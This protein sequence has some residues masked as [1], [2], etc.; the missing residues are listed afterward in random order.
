MNFFWIPRLCILTLLVLPS[1]AAQQVAET[2]PQTAGTLRSG[3]VISRNYSTEPYVIEKY[4]TAWRFENDGTAD[5]TITARIRIQNDVAARQF[6]ELSFAFDANAEELRVAFLRVRKSDG[7]VVD[8]DPH[9]ITE[10][11]S[12][13]VRDAPAFTNAKEKHATATR[14]RLT[15]GSHKSTK[16]ER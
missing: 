4:T 10:E 9:S 14:T 2:R 3:A 15:G 5:R 13:A 7:A 8:A 1:A 16:S 11:T 6:S 12:P